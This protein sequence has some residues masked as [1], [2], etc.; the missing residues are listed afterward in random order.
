MK[1]SANEV[2]TLATKAARG[3]GAPPAQATDF[4][5]AALCHLIEGRA[6]EDL[7]EALNALPK[8]PILSVPPA[9]ARLV[10]SAEGDQASGTFP[11][12]DDLLLSYAQSQPFAAR[13]GRDGDRLTLTLQLSKPNPTRP[14]ARVTLPDA[15]Y[16]Q[17]QT[18]A[19]K[20]L[21]PESA[22]SRL[23]GAGAGLTDND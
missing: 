11:D 5:R 9:I 23:S 13:I 14:V 4:G 22:A 21:V 20:T 12:A 2:T 1:V 3:G 18:L 19:A 15:L 6:P 8:G 16:D 10:E 17:M 7:A